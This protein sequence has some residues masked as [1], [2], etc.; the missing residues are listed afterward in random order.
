MS[1]CPV[2]LKFDS[3]KINLFLL[4]IWIAVGLPWEGVETGWSLR[5]LATQFIPWFCDS[6]EE[7]KSHA[8]VLSLLT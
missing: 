6:M 2:S 8:H 5:A 7:V 1:D 4:S 3:F